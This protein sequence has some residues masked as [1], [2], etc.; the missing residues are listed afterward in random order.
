[1]PPFREEYRDSPPLDGPPLV[2]GQ[3]HQQQTNANNNATNNTTT[4]T[5]SPN[6][7][8]SARVRY[9]GGGQGNAQGTMSPR[10]RRR[11]IT[12]IN[13]INVINNYAPRSGSANGPNN[14]GSSI[15]SQLGWS[16]I[17]LGLALLILLWFGA[18]ATV[19]KNSSSSTVGTTTGSPFFSEDSSGGLRANGKAHAYVAAG[20]KDVI[21]SKNDEPKGQTNQSAAADPPNIFELSLFGNQSPSDFQLYTPHAPSCSKHLDAASVSFTLVSQLS[22]DRIW[23][24]KHHCERWGD[25]PMS[26]AIFSDRSA[27]DVKSQLVDEGCSEEHL[28]VQT[29]SRT[30]YDPSGKEYPVN[31]LRNLAYSAVKTT[32]I[33]YADV[34]FWPSSDLHEILSHND[35]RERFA[36]DPKLATVIPVFQM[37]RRCRDYEDCRYSNIPSMPRNKKA[38]LALIK[39]E[40]AST[41]DPTNVGGHGSTKYITWRDQKTGTFVDLPCIKSNRYEPYLAFRFCSDLPP[42][43]EGFT[44]YGKN[45]MTVSFSS[46]SRTV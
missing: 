22:N 3:H 11:H 8:A 16:S 35:I 21:K 23:M 40:W 19:M 33:I 13:R 42:F 34:D 6:N 26:I 12:N 27:E 38:L 41:F 2:G 43:Q 9:R 17:R 20:A 37:Y 29:V 45:K 39:E 18:V 25:N 32:H 28:T 1:M 46:R 36:S 44:G 14:K 24:I 30:K 7:R 10:S 5:T 31:L 15:K 4:T